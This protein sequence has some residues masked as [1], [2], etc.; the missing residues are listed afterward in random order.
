[1]LTA[2][3]PENIT[4]QSADDVLRVRVMSRQST[5]LQLVTDDSVAL[6]SP[7]FGARYRIEGMTVAD[8]PAEI[9]VTLPVGAPANTV[10]YAQHPTLPLWE[11]VPD[12]RRISGAIAARVTSLTSYAL[13]VTE[14]IDAP[15]FASDI[16]ELVAQA[17][18]TT[19]AYRVITSYRRANEDPSSPRIVLPARTKEGSCA[20]LPWNATEVAERERNARVRINGEEQDVIFTLTAFYFLHPDG[21]PRDTSLTM[22]E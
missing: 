1:M 8:V 18:A 16:D 6:E 14:S 19:V 10:L 21:C 9:A 17:P 11:V 5:A 15:E 7:L 20:S 2:G 12:T 13:G 22:H 3:I 4:F